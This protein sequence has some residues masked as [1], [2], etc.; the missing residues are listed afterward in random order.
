MFRNQK[1]NL[2]EFMAKIVVSA[3]SLPAG[4]NMSSQEEYIKRVQNYGADMYHLDVMD[5]VF[6]KRE[7]IDYNYFEQLRENSNL[8]FDVHLMVKSPKP[9]LIKKYI[10]NGANILTLQYESYDNKLALGK[11]LKLINK[12]ECM[13]G[14]AVDIDTDIKEILPYV[15]KVD[16]ILIMCVKTGAGGQT[17]DDRCLEK[18]KILRK[19]NKKILIEVD[20]GINGITAP[21]CVKAGADI[22]VSGSFIYENDTYEAIQILKGKS[23]G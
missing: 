20:G 15:D 12:T 5:G 21:K 14:L 13:C 17:F 16:L 2:G 22:L 9:S 3:S 8:L 7:T 18:I 10:K 11:C 19:A 23:N 4:R 1:I 6:V